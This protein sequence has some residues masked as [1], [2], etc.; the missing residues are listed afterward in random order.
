MKEAFLVTGV[1]TPFAKAGTELKDVHA[2]ELGRHALSELIA[3]LNVP[4]QELG[5][6][7]DEVIIGNTG[8]P[9]DSANVSR[10][11]ALRAGLPE[12]ISAYTVQ[13]NCASALEA[14]SQ[15]TLKVKSGEADI[16]F[17]GGTESMSQ[18]PLMYNSK[19]TKF[20][21]KL[22][23]ARSLGERLQ[24]FKDIP[25]PEFLK[26]RIAVM[27]G[28][29]DPFYSI[30]MGQTAEILAKEFHI[31]RKE[32][33]EFAL[34]SHRKA[35]KAID[36]KRLGDEI[37][38]YSIPPK[39]E[40]NLDHDSG[41]RK[42]QSLEALAKLKPFFDKKFGSITAGNSC[43]IT[44]GAVMVCVASEEGLRKLGQP[45]ALARISGYAFA[46]LDP[47]RMG[48]GPVFATQKL[49]KKTHDRLEDFDVIELN[50]AFAAQVI[51]C[52]KAFDSDKFCQEHFG[53]S[54]IGAINPQ[55]LNPNG[56]AIAIGHPV[57]ATGARIVLTAALELK[58]RGGKKALASLCIGGGQGGSLS[59]ESV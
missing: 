46:G 4:T 17:A 51:S 48:L 18:M 36:E 29:T 7:V 10:V 31:S 58:R 19:A 40:K 12:S 1:R 16:V 44:D 20:F 38:A 25:I 9:A 49:L 39:F 8:S 43:P 50:E 35:I 47:R 54:R 52:L 21:E 56:G 57:G 11:V 3:R 37:A 26:P 6:I 13:R 30:N 59:L 5:R 14:L 22:S 33:D 55:N 28:L 32:Q 42:E 24:V 34:W 53:E 2:T 23:R 45:Q 27:E 41:P 15:A